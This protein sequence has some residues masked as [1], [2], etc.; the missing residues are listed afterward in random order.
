MK[1]QIFPLKRPTFMLGLGFV[2]FGAS[3][4]FFYYRA[5]TNDR[6]LI[7]NGIIEMGP[8]AADIFYAVFFV[9]SAIMS[10]AGLYLSIRLLQIKDFRI[11][12]GEENVLVPP[13]TLWKSFNEISIPL[14]SIVSVAQNG[15]ALVI[16]TGD[17]NHSISAQWFSQYYPMAEVADAIIA[18]VRELHAQNKSAPKAKKSKKAKARENDSNE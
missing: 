11:V 18:R 10:L 13:P 9:L 4:A 14:N 15:Y 5:T 7:I 1:P 16:G 12:I 8:G 3:A 6:G 17:K 2:L